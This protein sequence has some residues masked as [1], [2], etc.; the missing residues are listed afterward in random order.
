MLATPSDP[1]ESHAAFVVTALRHRLRVQL[2]GDGAETAAAEFSTAWR[3]LLSS[4]D[5]DSDRELT[6]HVPDDEPGSI[7]TAQA[8]ASALITLALI[9]L[10]RGDGLLFHA[11]ASTD[12]D[13]A[14]VLLVGRSGA[15]KTTA[16]AHL[17][18]MTSYL[19]DE[20]VLV[21]GEGRVVPYPKPLSVVGDQPEKT[22]LAPAELGL[23]IPTADRLPLAR[24][25]VVDRSDERERPSTVTRLRSAEG[26]LAV[27]PQLSGLCSHPAPLVALARLSRAIGGFER[28]V[29]SEA[30]DMDAATGP[31]SSPPLSDSELAFRLAPRRLEPDTGARGL[32]QSPVD[33]AIEFS[34]TLLIAQGGRVTALSGI[35]MSA[36]MQ[37]VR[38]T[39]DDVLLDRLRAVHGRTPDDARHFRRIVDELVD[40]GILE[41]QS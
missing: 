9:E 16:V 22:Q 8:R 1:C 28:L 26:I 4:D 23:E 25:L 39:P 19:T 12:A 2:T 15:G 7:A 21:D 11:A 20:T 41:W 32:V 31:P 14:A 38:P 33:D 24:V 35:A 13:G 37:S 29:Y 30:R 18:R 17:A 40:G 27:I 10:N 5:R 36:W 34:D 3:H 6:I